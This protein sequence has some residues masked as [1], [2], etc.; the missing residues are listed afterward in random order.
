MKLLGYSSALSVQPDETLAFKVS[1]E[2]ANYSA[3]VVRLIHGDDRPGSPGFKC[4]H[5]P[6]S[7]DGEYAGDVQALHPGSC[8]QIPFRDGLAL[9]DSFTVEMWIWPT[10]PGQAKGVLLSQEI[11]RAHV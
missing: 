7:V 11:G 4:E 9:G 2:F 1:S 8:V 10:M 3:R 5:V 6:S